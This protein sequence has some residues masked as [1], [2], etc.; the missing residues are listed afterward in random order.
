MEPFIAFINF[1]QT[2]MAFMSHSYVVIGLCDSW[3]RR[4]IGV[5]RKRRW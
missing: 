2:L 3:V 4:A 1:M 5:L